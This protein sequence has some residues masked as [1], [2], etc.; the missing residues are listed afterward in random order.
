[1]K[2]TI[3]GIETSCDDSSVAIVKSENETDG[4]VLFCV[5]QNQDKYH[6]VY[7]GVVPE[8]ASRNHSEHL[9]PMIDFALKE[10]KLSFADVS[11]IAVTT[12]PGLV[13]SLM[14][15]IVTAKALAIANSVPWV[16]VNHIRAHI[17]SAFLSDPGETKDKKPNF[18]FVSMV[19]SGGHTHLFLVSSFDEIKLIGR[20]ADDAAGEALDKFAKLVG[21]GFPGGAKV[22]QHSQGANSKAFDFVRPMMNTKNLAMSFSGL[23]TSAANLL[24]PLSSE[25]I[26]QNLNDLCASYQEAVVDIL[27]EKLRLAV[28][29]HKVKCVSIVGGV[30]ANSRLRVRAQELAKVLGLKL[31]IPHVKYS[32]DNAAMIGFAG[33]IEFRQSRFPSWDQGPLPMSQP[34]DFKTS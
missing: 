1:M 9:L 4:E 17:L 30:S 19:V 13:G 8:I 16:S 12:R 31:V 11:A 33:A 26:K 18:P 23:K 6:K 27:I 22:D 32:T 7:G 5:S 10:T 25:N 3:L 34:Q 15:G 20:T 28:E 29:L 24:Q 14:V 21:L 2:S